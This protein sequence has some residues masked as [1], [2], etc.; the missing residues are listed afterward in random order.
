MNYKRSK[1]YLRMFIGFLTLTLITLLGA[2]TPSAMT[3]ISTNALP[4]PVEFEIYGGVEDYFDE[5]DTLIVV[6]FKFQNATDEQNV[7]FELIGPVGW[8]DGESHKTILERTLPNND[9]WWL[10]LDAPI[11]VGTYKAI[12]QVDGKSYTSSVDIDVTRRLPLAVISLSSAS[13]DR[14]DASWL[15]VPGAK[16]Y[17]VELYSEDAVLYTFYTEETNISFTDFEEP[18]DITQ[19]YYLGVEAFSEQL[20][21]FSGYVTELPAL[22]ANVN[23]SFTAVPINFS[24]NPN[25]NLAATLE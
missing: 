20:Y 6:D 23:A 10:N 16:Q 11:V 22:P 17:Y 21:D 24:I 8:N 18:L 19:R 3:S 1:N 4:A 14:V 5:L 13:A 7:P 2:C 25:T 15:A 9:R 12:V